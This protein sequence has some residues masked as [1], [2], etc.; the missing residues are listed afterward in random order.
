MYR[1]SVLFAT[2]FLAVFSLLGQ[3]PPASQP[4]QKPA[5]K[6][7]EIIKVTTDLVTTPVSVVDKNGRFI[8][9]LKQKDFKIFE[10]GIE[11]KISYFQSSEMPF[12][13]I[14]L[15][16]I[17]PST[18]YRMDEIHFAALTFVNQLRPADKVMVIAFD[19]RIRVLTDE[20]TSDKQLIYSAIYKANFGSGTSLYDA[21][22]YATDLDM[23]KVPG[24]KAVVIFTD[25]VDT[26]SRAATLES[27][28][29]GVQ[30]VDALIYPIRYN[31]AR[32]TTGVVSST[33]GTPVPLPPD[34]AAILAQRGIAIDPR[35]QVSLGGGSS[36]AA[37]ARGKMYLEKLAENTGGRI[38]EADDV[39]NLETAFAG[40]AE[41]LRRQYS[42][43]YYPEQEGTPGERRTVK[44][45]VP[46]K[47]TVIVRAK[48]GYVIRSLRSDA[49]A[50]SGPSVTGK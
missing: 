7:D 34:V 37:Y 39:K 19:Q 2:L 1:V 12:T 14:L 5:D 13:V 45:K 3:A 22:F 21:V 15:L 42:L 31:T 28:L 16:D 26:T 10:N 43:G 25:G 47:P 18:K 32:M 38:F 30:E 49:G 40:V 36:P 29:L 24:R 50:T 35:G 44:I 41:E 23:I 20:P 8:P 46:L 48:S 33:T 17:S 6:D 11:Q 4:P 27:T 9:G